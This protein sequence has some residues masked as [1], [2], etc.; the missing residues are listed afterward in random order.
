MPSAKNSRGGSATRSR[1]GRDATGQESHDLTHLGGARRWP[2]RRTM[3]AAER[4]PA[5][6]FKEWAERKRLVGEEV[7][8]LLAF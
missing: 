8:L 6:T 2:N 1:D 5:K 3:K 7:L 4:L